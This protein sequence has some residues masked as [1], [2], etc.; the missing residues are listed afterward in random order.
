MVR[1]EATRRASYAPVFIMTSRVFNF[2]AGPAVLPTPVL[3][4]MR[5]HLLA[6]PG[7][8]MS[9][10]EI[11]HRSSA[12]DEVLTTAEANIRSLASIPDDYQV[13]FMQGGATHQFAMVPMNLFLKSRPADYVV[14]G[15]WAQ[16]AAK[17]AAKFGSARVAATTELSL[18]HISEPTRPY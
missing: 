6:L 2:G 14:T 4:Q 17:E 3:E 10:L 5:E 7:I 15:S 11:S 12:F 9:I 1:A 8:G 16:K 13:L 18:I